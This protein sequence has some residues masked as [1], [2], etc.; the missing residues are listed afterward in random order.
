MR[1]GHKSLAILLGWWGVMERLKKLESQRRMSMAAPQSI[2]IPILQK[3]RDSREDWVLSLWLAI[4]ILPRQIYH[5]V[6]GN[7]DKMTM[8]CLGDQSNSTKTGPPIKIL[9]IRKG[10]RPRLVVSIL[11]KL[12]LHSYYPQLRDINGFL[13]EPQFFMNFLP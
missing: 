10:R 6:G 11:W 4:N 2:K 3:N 5:N 12:T 1:R 7:Y 8:I 9:G 13:Q